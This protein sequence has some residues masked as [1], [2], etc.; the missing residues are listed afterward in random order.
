MMDLRPGRNTVV[1]RLCVILLIGVMIGA[2]GVTRLFSTQDHAT[3]PKTVLIQPGSSTSQIAALLQREG[4]VKSSFLFLLAVKLKGADGKLQAGEYQL[5]QEASMFRLIEKLLR[6][7]PPSR[8]VTVKEGLTV[9]EIAE[10]IEQNGL[11]KREEFIKAASDPSLIGDFLPSGFKGEYPLEGYLFPDT[12][13]IDEQSSERQIVETMVARFRQVFTEDLRRRAQELNMTPHEVITLASIIEKEAVVDW[14][15]AKISGVFH[16]R[17]KL[18]MKLDADPTVLYALKKR[19]GV[20][21]LA[22]L[23]VNSPY[24]TYKVA[25]LPPGPICSPGLASIRA[26]LY[27]ETH[28]YLYFVSKN[29][30]THEFNSSYAAHLRSVR[31][32]Q[33]AR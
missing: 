17:L 28:S 4:I 25:G 30:G 20:P 13:R 23:N 27:P 26:A 10:V 22:D 14:E 9:V 24:N 19:G 33:S 2:W 32:Y 6:G 21:T 8:T 16:N 12:Y 7:Q 1:A 29:D 11:G 31:K 3:S 18:G 15:R 5:G